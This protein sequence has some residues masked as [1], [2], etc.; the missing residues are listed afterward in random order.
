MQIYLE[1]EGKT[2]LRQGFSLSRTAVALGGFDAIHVGHQAIIRRVVAAARER[3]LSA[4]VH[5]F[6]NQPR[7]VLC[8]G[9]AEQVCDMETRL[10][11]LEQLGVDAVVAQWFTRDYLGITPQMFVKDWL[12]DCLDAK[13]LAAGF[14]YH[15]GSGKTGDAAMLER[16]AAPLGMTVSCVPCVEVLGKPVSSTRIRELIRAGSMEEAAACLGRPFS[17]QGTVV[18]GNQ[19]GRTIGFPTANTEIPS[20]LILPK[21]GVYVTEAMADGVWYTAITNVGSKPTVV[22]NQTCIETHLLGYHGD[23]YGKKL[24]LRFYRHLRDITRFP[25]LDALRTQLQQDSAAARQY[26]KERI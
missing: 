15:F 14:N 24:K 11:V 6:C 20:G 26:Q 3:G 1:E 13:F 18:C 2:L 7:T 21:F 23:L 5:L 16:L 10:A 25:S 17:M 4:V 12:K 19:I 9:A 8:G 22:P